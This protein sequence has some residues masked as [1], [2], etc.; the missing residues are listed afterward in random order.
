[1]ITAAH[2]WHVIIFLVAR[3]SDVILTG[4]SEV[5][6]IFDVTGEVFMSFVLHPM[7]IRLLIIP[8][9]NSKQNN[10]SDLPDEA[11]GRQTDADI[12]VLLPAEIA[13]HALCTVPHGVDRLLMM[14]C[15]LFSLFSLRSAVWSQRISAGLFIYEDL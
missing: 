6:V 7:G 15:S 8:N 2:H 4:I 13:A 12:G 5:E 11:D 14:L 3:R 9:E 1:M 10:H